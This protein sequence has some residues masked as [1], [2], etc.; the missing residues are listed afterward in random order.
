MQKLETKINEGIDILYCLNDIFE[1]DLPDFSNKLSNTFILTV[2]PVLISSFFQDFPKPFQ[3]SINVSLTILVHI[4]SFISSPVLLDEICKLLLSPEVGK[5]ILEICQGNPA[6]SASEDIEINTGELVE[7]PVMKSFLLIFQ[8]GSQDEQMLGLMFLQAIIQNPAI[9]KNVLAD[10]GLLSLKY[11]RKQELLSGILG[12][13]NIKGDYNGFLIDL[14]LADLSPSNNHEFIS[15]HAGLKILAEL[16]IGPNSRLSSKHTQILRKLLYA[17]LFELKTLWNTELYCKVIIEFFETTW[18]QIKKINLNAIIPLNNF[19]YL[20]NCKTTEKGFRKLSADNAFSMQNYEKIQLFLQVFFLI[21]KILLTLE[22]KDPDEYPVQSGPNALK[23]FGDI[24]LSNL[25][26]DPVI[27]NESPAVLIEND[28]YFILA[29]P[30]SPLSQVLEL[31]KWKNLMVSP[32]FRTSTILVIVKR[33]KNVK[34]CLKLLEEHDL[35]TMLSKLQQRIQYA[36]SLE[37]ELIESFFEDICEKIS[38]N[39]LI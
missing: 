26:G 36:L 30:Q 23:R 1:Q 4:M 37:G 15:Y 31:E 28:D 38:N 2:F 29:K 27:Y 16:A 13:E 35:Y 10:L 17:F 33:Q 21:R 32:D 22:G 5:K 11:L 20:L 9:S 7:N 19:K 39:Y 12:I 24:D 25:Y 34:F 3:I 8:E 14:I 18:E 6:N